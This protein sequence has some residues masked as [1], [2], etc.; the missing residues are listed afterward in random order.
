MEHIKLEKKAKILLI[1][2]LRTRTITALQKE[3]LVNVLDLY[4]YTIEIIDKREQ[5]RI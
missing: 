2:I 3:E 1:E 4:G 5:V